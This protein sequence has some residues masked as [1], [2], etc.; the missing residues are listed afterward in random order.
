MEVCDGQHEYRAVPNAERRSHEPGG[1][2]SA[3]TADPALLLPASDLPQ[4][5][6]VLRGCVGDIAAVKPG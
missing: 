3:A 6:S 2:T 1:A 5:K 4:Q